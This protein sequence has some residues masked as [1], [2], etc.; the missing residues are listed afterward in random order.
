MKTKY[1]SLDSYEL[2]RLLNTAQRN[3]QSELNS[4]LDL[5]ISTYETIG[6]QM[7]AEKLKLSWLSIGSI[8]LFYVCYNIAQFYWIQPF[9]KN[10]QTMHN[11]CMEL[12]QTQQEMIKLQ[13]FEIEGSPMLKFLSGIVG[14]VMSVYFKAFFSTYILRFA[15]FKKYIPYV[16]FIHADAP[17]GVEDVGGGNGGGGDPDLRDLE[18]RLNV[19]RVAYRDSR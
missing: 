7:N 3:R 6:K 9:L 8:L 1:F 5:A 13:Q 12:I 16:F 19:L 2:E 4:A 15:W 11:L 14:F 18:K 10:Q 17:N